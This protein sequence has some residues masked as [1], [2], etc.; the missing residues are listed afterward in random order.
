MK[1]SD[2]ASWNLR[3]RNSITLWE[4]TSSISIIGSNRKKEKILKRINLS[5][6]PMQLLVLKRLTL[7]SR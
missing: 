1:R 7:L 4:S 6:D 3:K 5:N 2:Y